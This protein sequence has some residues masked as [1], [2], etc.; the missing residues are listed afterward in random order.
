VTYGDAGPDLDPADDDPE[1]AD[2]MSAEVD[3]DPEDVTDDV[4]RGSIP[5]DV[6]DT[7][8]AEVPEEGDD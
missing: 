2:D 6:G 5:D 1:Y 4:K 7:D 3:V 8:R